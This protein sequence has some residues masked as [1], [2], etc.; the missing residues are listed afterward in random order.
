MAH[1]LWLRRCF[2]SRLH[3]MVTAAGAAIPASAWPI[4]QH[5]D[6]H[7]VEREIGRSLERQIRI[8]KVRS[9]QKA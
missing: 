2:A 6:L 1:G 8:D 4:D 7:V 3:P 5:P 9:L